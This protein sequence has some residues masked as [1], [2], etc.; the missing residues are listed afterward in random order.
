ML[1]FVLPP[2]VW[3]MGRRSLAGLSRVRRSCALWLRIILVVLLVASL[4]RPQWNRSSDALS[5]YFVVD[6]SKSIPPDNLRKVNA[7]LM[8][9]VEKKP[10]RDMAGLIY[11][12]ANAICEQPPSEL[13]LSLDRQVVVDRNGTDIAEAL[14]LASFTFPE[15][16]RK[17]VVLVTDGNQNSSDAMGEI[18]RL[19][20]AGIQVDVIPVEYDYKNEIMVEKAV[21]PDQIRAGSPFMLHVLVLST[22]EANAIV[23]V[24]HGGEFL[25]QSKVHLSEGANHLSFPLVLAGKEMV[26][27]VK[28]LKVSVTPVDVADDQI[29]DN[30]STY[31]FALMT[32]PPS[33]LYIDG[34]LGANDGYR[35]FLHEALLKKLRLAKYGGDGKAPEVTLKVCGAYDIPAEQELVS[36][37]CI[38]ID[39]LAAEY[40]G[41]PRMERI[42]SL[43][44]ALGTGLVMIGGENSF[45]VGNYRNTPVEEALP[46]DMDL[47]NKKIMPSGALILVI[48]RSGSMEGE[49][50]AQAKAAAW[51]AAEVLSEY[52]YLGVIAFDGQPEWII[53]PVL[54]KNRSWIRSKIKAVGS[55]GGTE[56]VSALREAHKGLA[57][58]TASLKHVILLSDGQSSDQGLEE[59]MSNMARDKITV[60]TVGIGEKD[61]QF[62]M[63][64]IA[65]KGSGRFYFVKDP[66]KL[67]RIFIKESLFVKRTLLF[68]DAFIP[69]VS[70]GRDEFLADIHGGKVPTLYG[71]VATTAKPDADVPL[72]STNENHDPILAHWRYGLGRSVAFTS[73]VKNRWG[74]DWIGWSGFSDFW[75]GL[76]YRIL[77]QEPANLRLISSVN[78]DEGK[79]M[80]HAIN[81]HG[82]P[83]SFLELEA[84]VTTPELKV[85]RLQLRQTGVCTYEGEF[86]AQETG[87]YEI[88]V[89]EGGNRARGNS[90]VYGGVAKPFSVE[91]TDFSANDGMLS[92][93]VQAGGGE[94]FSDNEPG[95]Y[96]YR[97]KGLLPA[98][99]FRDCWTILLALFCVLFVLDVCVRRVMID[100]SEVGGFVRKR[101]L[102]W[103]GD[104]KGEDEMVRRLTEA[105]K[106]AI[107]ERG[108]K[109]PAFLDKGDFSASAAVKITETEK[110]SSDSIKNDN[111]APFAEASSDPDD[112]QSSNTFTSRLLNA[113]RRV[114]N[115]ENQKSR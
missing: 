47:K 64:E 10:R 43:V 3:W 19:R 72:V 104:G 84:T 32:G 18:E 14:R 106:R 100:F 77:R 36:Y 13:P 56:I 1:L 22:G 51:A 17:R 81:D 42:R 5:V 105:K 34:N 23:T 52:D 85:E 15:G 69:E 112:E 35:P 33:I 71:Y 39:N 93:F 96:A 66:K 94:L 6:L 109:K 111:V 95:D 57:P 92:R 65:N 38:I 103:R 4:A 16:V 90:A 114:E 88:A 110:L 107:S 8:D 31:A 73:D 108:R 70:N 20:A 102:A 99:H 78:G 115:S 83:L 91:S 24:Q 40:L 89:V 86:K 97:R 68:E 74:K 49:K 29:D 75:S 12:G 60:S 45:G 76:V 54:A 59:L 53:K 98:D 30:N 50:L 9:I 2:A 26:A 46:V 63:Q 62:F 82:D 37:S 7:R 58:L 67:P 61:G 41:G 21:M 87:R 79:I 48:D 44:N 11:F 55:G 113:K 101:Y 25:D 27:G 28:T 80:V